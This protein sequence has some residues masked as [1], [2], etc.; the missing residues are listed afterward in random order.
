MT[1]KSLAAVLVEDRK[2]EI[3]EFD[4]PDVPDGGAL[5]K[6]EAC[7]I[8]GSDIHGSERIG[9]GPRILGHENVGLIAATGC[10]GSPFL[11]EAHSSLGGHRVMG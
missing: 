3:R 6:V 2:F 4:L 1:E 11:A 9:T 8:C 7:G 5:L 10:N